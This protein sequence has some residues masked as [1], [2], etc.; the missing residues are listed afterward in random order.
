MRDRGVFGQGFTLIEL[1]IVVAI[2]GILMA[3]VYPAYRRHVVRAEQRTAVMGMLE[4]AAQVEKNL[5]K[6]PAYLSPP[7]PA[8]LPGMVKPGVYEIRTTAAAGQYTVTTTFTDA[9]GR[10]LP[11]STISI[12]QNSTRRVTP[13]EPD[14]DANDAN[15]IAACFGE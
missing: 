4:V 11:C 8:F 2:L 15:I 3:I 9:A 12:D 6:N 1:M 14:V 5:L 13:T 10:G 7:L